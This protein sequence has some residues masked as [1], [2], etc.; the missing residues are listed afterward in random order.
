MPI[1]RDGGIKLEEIWQPL[2]DML[3]IPQASKA[4]CVFFQKDEIS[5]DTNV[6]RGQLTR[7]KHYSAWGLNVH[8]DRELTFDELSTSD[9]SLMVGEHEYYHSSLFGLR[10]LSSNQ[11]YG[12]FHQET[13]NPRDMDKCDLRSEKTKAVT[14]WIPSVQNF[15]VV[16]NMQ[17]LS[18]PINMLVK[19]QGVLYRPI[20]QAEG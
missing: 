5:N 12:G 13:V 1:F 8:T 3:H 14:V 20:V 15:S 9:I 16:V 19:I 4:R 7:P 10:K 6:A 2:F 17:Q 18:A 11:L